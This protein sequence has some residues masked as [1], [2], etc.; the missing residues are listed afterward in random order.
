MR[1]LE[2]TS[3]DSEM[4]S[5]FDTW[6]RIQESCQRLLEAVAGCRLGPQH[7]GKCYFYFNC[8]F[9]V[10][11]QQTE[12]SNRKLCI[13]QP[14]A[15]GDIYFAVIRYW[16]DWYGNLILKVT[17]SGRCYLLII[18]WWEVIFISQ[19]LGIESIG[20]APLEIVSYWQSYS[21]LYSWWR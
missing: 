8:Y 1:S 20:I 10:Q 5:Q 12:T 16:I 15:G 2:M 4:T 21:N 13:F 3:S 7:D 17:N 6:K 19:L 11:L 9:F 18:V 14:G